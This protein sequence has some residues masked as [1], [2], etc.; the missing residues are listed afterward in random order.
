MTPICTR[1]MEP[2]TKKRYHFALSSFSR[3]Y[4]VPHVTQDM[5]DF[6]FV[7]ALGEEI[8]PLDCLN[9]VDRYFRNLWDTSL[10]GH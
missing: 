1:E 3:I 7:W 2:L 10:L 5:A 8:A 9:H 4:G 6:C